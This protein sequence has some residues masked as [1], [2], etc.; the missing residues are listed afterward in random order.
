MRG[1]VLVLH[2]ITDL[3]RA[4]RVRR[5]FVANVSHELR[6]PLTAVRGYVEALL[7]E[8]S[9]A[10]ESRKFL[11]TI[12]S[13][14]YIILTWGIRS[15]MKT[16][17]LLLQT[18]ETKPRDE[19]AAKGLSSF[20][21]F[22]KPTPGYLEQVFYHDLKS[23]NAGNTCAALVNEELELGIAIRFNK[24]QLFN[25]THWKQSGEGDYVIGIEPCNSYGG[26]RADSKRNGVLEYLEPGEIRRFKVEA[27]IFDG[28]T[29]I[30]H[31]KKEISSLA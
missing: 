17:Y 3:R 8:G 1:A 14:F 13:C 28:M 29:E 2:D 6:T 26:G 22:N 19:D 10:V 25:L 15:W 4:D 30:N 11:E 7:D 31:L 20:S 24:K 21:A 16:A 27:E 23:D 9:D 5:D 12:G 18:N